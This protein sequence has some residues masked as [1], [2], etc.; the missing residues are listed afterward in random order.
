VT[1]SRFCSNCGHSLALEC[2]NVLVN[3]GVSRV[4]AQESLMRAGGDFAVALRLLAL[5]ESSASSRDLFVSAPPSAPASV[6]FTTSLA[7]PAADVPSPSSVV[8]T[9]PVNVNVNVEGAS[10][11]AEAR[12]T[13]TV[14]ERT[15][16]EIEQRNKQFAVVSLVF[17]VMLIIGG[18]LTGVG[19]GKLIIGMAI[20]GIVL[21]ALT[22]CAWPIWAC[23]FW[24]STSAVVRN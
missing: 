11:S 17:L 8:V 3:N 4:L 19:F 20:A 13:R 7:P 12:T 1:C 14:R 15:P 24:S 16:Q 23:V 21:L 10:A 22:C 2:E 5:A 6:S 9:T 18:V